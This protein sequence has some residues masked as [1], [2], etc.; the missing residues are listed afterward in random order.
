[1]ETASRVIGAIRPMPNI[2]AAL[3]ALDLSRKEMPTVVGFINQHALN[4]ALADEEFRV[5]LLSADLLLRDGKG[6]EM[7][8][9]WL[10]RDPGANL[11]GTDLIPL[12]L[13]R[14]IGRRVALFGT[15]EPW[16]G[17]ARARLQREGHLVVAAMDGFKDDA[18]YI[19][20]VKTRR[21]EIV[22]LAM[23]MPRQE[24]VAAVLAQHAEGPL[25][26]V[27]GGAIL[28]FLAGRVSRAPA[29]MRGAGLE[30]AYRLMLEPRRLARRYL[31]GIPLFFLHVTRARW[32]MKAVLK[33]QA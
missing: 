17:Q 5:D 21:P 10:G 9:Q 25:L 1:M 31:L 14:N 2:S 6:M 33:A 8:C 26:I 24:H 22:I 15:T 18:A 30:W 4:M 20:T 13:T 7:A 12:L 23:G 32:S 29:W 16:L 11:N 3:D 19:E 28:D 27:N